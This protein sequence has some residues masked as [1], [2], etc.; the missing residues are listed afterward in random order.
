MRKTFT[1]AV[2]VAALSCG[3]TVPAL[4]ADWVRIGSVDVSHGVDRD[5]AYTRFGGGVDRLRLDVRDSDVQCRSVRA[6]FA[7]GSS[8]EIF[9]G[10]LRAGR[11]VAI[12]MPG[13]RARVRKLDFTCRASARR[14]ATISISAEVNSYRDEW[15]RSPD[16]ERS[17]SR[18]FNWGPAVAPPPHGQ[19]GWNDRDWVSIAMQSFE[20]RGDREVAVAGWRGRSVDRIALRPLNGDARCSRVTVRFNNGQ[21]R[22][23]N[24]NRGMRLAQGRAQT[25][26]LPGRDRNVRDVLLQC[27]PQNGRSVRIEVLARK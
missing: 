7:N 21:A 23:L 2:A 13:E 10:W 6:T 8:R 4:A 20:G 24:V 17:W 9:K 15:R 22:D 26:D 19:M 25:F 5:T 14:G 16:W 18:L 3:L 27:S 1:L 11:S 12:E